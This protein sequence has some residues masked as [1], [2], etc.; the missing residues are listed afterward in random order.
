MNN[1]KDIISA[2]GPFDGQF[3]VIKETESHKEQTVY[4]SRKITENFRSEE[5]FK[6]DDFGIVSQEEVF[7][8]N[9]HPQPLSPQMS[10]AK[11]EE[12]VGNYMFSSN[13]GGEAP[14][15]DNELLQEDSIILS[16]DE[17]KNS[18]PSRRSQWKS[19]K[20]TADFA[21][22]SSYKKKKKREEPHSSNKKDHQ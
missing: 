21:S 11:L 16:C 13:N 19:I 20:K 15:V 3:N 12:R 1:S 6:S 18:H 4:R 22:E 2:S 5:D 17:D 7:P 14:P 9:N 8:W 10:H